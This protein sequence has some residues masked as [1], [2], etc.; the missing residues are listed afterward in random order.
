MQS[1]RNNEYR[2]A[3]SRQPTGAHHSNVCTTSHAEGV[4]RVV[5][6]GGV[7]PVSFQEQGIGCSGA[8]S[9]PFLVVEPTLH[10]RPGSVKGFRRVW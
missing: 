6:W 2:Q 9:T 4:P 10:Y 8:L 1:L 5:Q 7:R 3:P